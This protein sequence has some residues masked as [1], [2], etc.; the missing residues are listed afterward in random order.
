MRRLASAA[1]FVAVLSSAAYADGGPPRYRESG[2]CA[3][4]SWTGI[5]VGGHTGWG[6]LE[7][8]LPP[9]PGTDAP[10]TPTG[11]FWGGQIG[12]NYQFA[13]NW[14]VGAEVDGAFARLEDSHI[15]PDSLFPLTMIADTVKVN[16][17]TTLRGRVGFALD[18]TLIYATGGRAWSG[19]EVTTSSSVS[20]GGGPQVVTDHVT[21]GGWTLGG[22]IE[23]ALWG[24][25]TGKLEYQFIRNDEVTVQS[26][27]GPTP[28]VRTELQTLRIGVNYLFR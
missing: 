21:I 28:H 16:W 18:R 26:Q 13:R 11:G 9:A 2:C 12:A 7:I 19:A 8:F 20:G 23:A 1:A 6:S 3:P 17:L 14:I 4:F 25:W 10:P 15:R 27:G 24:N 5:Y 22:G